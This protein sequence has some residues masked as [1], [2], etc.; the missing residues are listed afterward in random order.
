[1]RDLLYLLIE[2]QGEETNVIFARRLGIPTSTWGMTRARKRKIGSTILLAV[3]TNF[4]DLY[5]QSYY[6]K[7]GIK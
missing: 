1:M 2:K 6:Y 3:L 4:P 5:H 7:R